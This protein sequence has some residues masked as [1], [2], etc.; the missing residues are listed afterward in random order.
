[1]FLR[2]ANTSHFAFHIRM[3]VTFHLCFR[4]PREC[5]LSRMHSFH[6]KLSAF[7]QFPVVY[8]SCL[9]TH[10]KNRCFISST[11]WILYLLTL[12]SDANAHLHVSW[13]VLGWFRNCI[14][15][16]SPPNG[17]NDFTNFFFVSFFQSKNNTKHVLH[18]N[19]P[20]G[21]HR[22]FFLTALIALGSSFAE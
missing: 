14:K 16:T 6:S 10:E 2:I 13:M 21:F 5:R 4:S 11:F 8:I 19:V 1:M 3:S 12:F 22:V 18:V 17:K 20:F 9:A 15:C 7:E